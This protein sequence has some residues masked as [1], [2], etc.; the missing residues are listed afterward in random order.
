MISQ[1]YVDKINSWYTRR[2]STLTSDYGWL[3]VVGLEWLK[4]GANNFS[5]LGT[6]TLQRGKVSVELPTGLSGLIGEHTFTS[7]FIKTEADAKGPD[8]VKVG[9]RALV[10][11]QRGNRFALRMWDTNAEARKRFAGIDRYP[12]SE[13]WKIE[14][15][16]EDYK[17]SKVVKLPTAI[18]RYTEE[19]EVPG[20]ALL[21]FGGNAMKLEPIVE[22][23]SKEL[24]FIF[25]DGTSGQETFAD[26]RYLYAPPPGKG[27]VEIDF[28][29][30]I[31]PPSAFTR[32][33][34][35]PLALESN[36]LSVSIEAGEKAYTAS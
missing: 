7:G 34:T 1:V 25:K 30:A 6:I 35:S 15:V 36:R 31:N 19:Y 33:A 26:G 24:F 5:N 28:N 4:E 2:T 3:T 27:S 11:L 22:E 23:G 13:K 16:W 10:I 32:C 12:V 20:F 9:S 14:A 29:K 18:P 21:N 8:K 17:K